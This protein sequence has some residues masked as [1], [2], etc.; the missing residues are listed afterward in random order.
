MEL[1]ETY[2]LLPI[3]P[4]RLTGHAFSENSAQIYQQNLYF[5]WN[6]LS[7]YSNCKL[8]YLFVLNYTSLSSFCKF[9]LNNNEITKQQTL[10]LGE[11]VIMRIAHIQFSL[12][13]HAH[14]KL[15][16]WMH[17]M[18]PDIIMMMPWFHNE[19]HVIANVLPGGAFLYAAL[20]SRKTTYYWIVA[21][22]Y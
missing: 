13:K 20:N 9:V 12:V 8:D 1:W 17:N 15:H 16:L 2:F 3:T 19:L 6:W 4:F 10:N 21:Y 11:P 7:F 22:F 18:I 14:L 5:R